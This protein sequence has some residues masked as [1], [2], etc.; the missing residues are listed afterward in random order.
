MESLGKAK[1]QDREDKAMTS[2]RQ[3]AQVLPAK[4]GKQALNILSGRLQ[5]FDAIT[6]SFSLPPNMNIQVGV[7]GSPEACLEFW[8]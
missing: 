2:Y 6:A 7:S 3:K 8:T 5:E 4:A 1:N